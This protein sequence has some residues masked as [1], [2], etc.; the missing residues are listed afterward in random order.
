MRILYIA[1]NRRVVMSRKIRVML[2]GVV[3]EEEGATA[4]EYAMII[5]LIALATF[6]VY[7]YVGVRV[8]MILDLMQL[9]LKLAT[10][11]YNPS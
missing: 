1:T 9:Q 6:A 3:G 5:G 10:K 2:W 11:V 8:F 7:K 4:V